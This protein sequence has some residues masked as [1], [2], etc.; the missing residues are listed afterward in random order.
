MLYNIVGNPNAK[1]QIQGR[2]ERHRSSGVPSHAVLTP[3]NTQIGLKSY[4]V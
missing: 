2:K 4:R 3:Q 1:I